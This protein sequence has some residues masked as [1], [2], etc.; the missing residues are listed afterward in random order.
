MERA[1]TITKQEGS[2]KESGFKIENTVTESWSMLTKIDTRDIGSREKGQDKGPTNTPMATP[3]Q[4]SGKMT[5]KMD[6][7]FSKWPP[8]TSTKATGSKARKMVLVLNSSNLGKYRFTNGDIYE[9]NFSNGNREGEGTYTWTDDSYYRGEWLSDKM[10]GYG[11]YRSATGD[12]INGY[13]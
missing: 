3:T 8:E 7:A 5:P 12:V 2:T 1:F 6:M 11:E 4:E 10:N 13:F 9:G